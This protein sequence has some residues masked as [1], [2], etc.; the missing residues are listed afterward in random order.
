MAAGM[1]TLIL[2]LGFNWIML[3]LAIWVGIWLAYDLVRAPRHH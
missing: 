2:L 1:L 3:G